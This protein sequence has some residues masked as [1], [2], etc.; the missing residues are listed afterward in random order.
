MQWGVPW[1]PLLELC[2]CVLLFWILSWFL[3]L[4]MD[5]YILVNFFF[6]Y[7]QHPLQW[8]VCNFQ[9]IDLRLRCITCFGQ[10]NVNIKCWAK[11]LRVITLLFCHLFPLAH[12]QVPNNV[13]YFILYCRM[14]KLSGEE[15]KPSSQIIWILLSVDILML[16]P[17]PRQ[18]K[19]NQYTK[20]TWQCSLLSTFANIRHDH[21]KTKYLLVLL[22]AIFLLLN[23]SSLF[24][25]SIYFFFLT[26]SETVFFKLEYN[27]WNFIFIYIFWFLWLYAIFI[28]IITWY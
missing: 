16:L 23:L 12:E 4:P 1:S 7:V 2:V 14:K 26:K 25:F 19:P 3:Y 22:L 8:E 18:E 5:I 28:I 20:V 6:F 17:K 10:W 9:P 15:E 21:F 27:L 24:F 13:C 11:A